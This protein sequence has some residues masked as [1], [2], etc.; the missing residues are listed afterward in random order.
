MINKDN[1]AAFVL[2]CQIW[3]CCIKHSFGIS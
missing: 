3:L 2:W 1:K